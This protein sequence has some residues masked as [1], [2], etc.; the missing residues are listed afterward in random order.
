YH[1]NIPGSCNFEAPDQ[2]WTSACGL[3]Q[4]LADDFDWNIINRAVTGHRAPETDHTPGKGQHFL[5]VNS[6]SQEEGDRARIITTKLFPPSLGICR[7]RFW[8]W[9]FPSRQ[10]GVLKV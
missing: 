3:T 8:F 2:E 10:T 7:V 6:S 5:Y 4:D 9:M 1:T